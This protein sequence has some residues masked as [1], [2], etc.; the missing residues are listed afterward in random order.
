MIGIGINVRLSDEQLASIGQPA[1]DLFRVCGRTVS[2]NALAG[3][4]INTLTHLLDGF[5]QGGFKLF[6]EQWCEYDA[7]RGKEVTLMASTRSVTG[8]YMGVDDQGDCCLKRLQAFMFLM[9]EKCHYG[10]HER[11]HGQTVA[12]GCREYPA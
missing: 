6:R 5:G 4:L 8:R 9:V 12:A 10:N 7:F 3:Q 11:T 2:R 1:V